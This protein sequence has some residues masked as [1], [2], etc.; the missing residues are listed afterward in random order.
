MNTLEYDTVI[1][2][3]P[4]ETVDARLLWQ[5]DSDIAVRE[6]SFRSDLTTWDEYHGWFKEKLSD[7]SFEILIARDREENP[8]GRAYL[9]IPGDHGVI[10]VAVAPEHRGKGHS[11]SLIRTATGYAFEKHAIRR[12]VGYIK[13]MNPASIHAFNS[14][15]FKQAGAAVVDDEDALVYEFRKSA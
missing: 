4:A 10:N 3:R 2:L 8:L 15:G 14:A 11:P 1:V 9:E 5:W 12:V 13:G 6:S 7:P